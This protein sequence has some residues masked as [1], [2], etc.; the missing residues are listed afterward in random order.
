MSQYIC[1]FC[2]GEFHTAEDHK[3]PGVKGWVDAPDRA[4]DTQAIA[5]ESKELNRK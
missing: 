3:C 4:V 5:K 1:H 2:R